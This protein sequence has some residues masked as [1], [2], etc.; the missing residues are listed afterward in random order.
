MAGVS[1]GCGGKGGGG[2]KRD[3][4]VVGGSGVGA[5]VDATPEMAL[6][7]ATAVVVT[8]AMRLGNAMMPQRSI[9]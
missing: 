8:A 7:T 6:T 9:W 3:C 2:D 5:S 4:G 1:G